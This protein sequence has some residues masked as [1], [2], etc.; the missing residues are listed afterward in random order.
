MPTGWLAWCID[1]AAEAGFPPLRK[2]EVIALVGREPVLCGV[3]RS[4]WRRCDLQAR[5]PWL[6][7]RHLTT[8]S[9][10]LHRCGIHCK[11][12]RVR[13]H[14]PDPDYLRKRDE[15]RWALELARLCPSQIALYY[16]DEAS[17]HRQPSLADRFGVVGLEPI[18][19]HAPRYDSRHRLCADLDA[20]C[21]R[22]IWI[23]AS[24]MTVPKLCAFLR[25]IRDADPDR[26][27]ML[28]WDNWPVHHHPRVLAEAKR[29][30]IHILWL[31]TYA[32]WLNPSEKLW[33]LLRQSVVHH[34]RLANQ[35]TE[36]KARV[37]TFLD[38]S[39][40]PSPDLIRY[41]GLSVQ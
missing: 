18:A 17:L 9:R 32:P 28:V 23:G 4:R 33:R 24:H 12:G 39:N 1:P 8:V 16:A 10:V 13:V 22:V 5:L 15:I 11:R 6:A 3:P 41:V 19:D 30:R 35:W 7:S 21:G 20:V 26:F 29:C 31:P 40:Q 25:A 14:S 34:H 38:Q 36:L 2:Q 27:L 37:T